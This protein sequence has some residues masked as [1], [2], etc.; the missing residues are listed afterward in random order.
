MKKPKIIHVNSFEEFL[1]VVKQ[2]QAGEHPLQ[3]QEQ[4]ERKNLEVGDVFEILEDVPHPI[5]DEVID[6]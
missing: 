6:I 3:K 1:Q 5:C 2:I 4:E